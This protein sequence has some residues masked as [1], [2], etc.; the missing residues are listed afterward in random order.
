M[1]PVSNLKQMLKCCFTTFYKYGVDQK[2][3]TKV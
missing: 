2:S 1:D 3:F